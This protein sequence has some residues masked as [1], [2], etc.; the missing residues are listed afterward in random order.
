MNTNSQDQQLNYY[1][2]NFM[3]KNHKGYFI[4]IGGADGIENSNT[5]HLEKHLGWDGV[6]IEANPQLFKRLNENRSC[7]KINTACG[8]TSGDALEFICMEQFS[9]FLKFAGK[10]KKWLLD[11]KKKNPK[12]S[13]SI[14]VKTLTEVLCEVDAPP[15]IDFF[16][17]DVEGA[18]LEVLKGINFNQHIFKT[19]LVEHNGEQPK[20][21]NI[22][23]L[24]QEVYGYK[25]APANTFLRDDFY[26]K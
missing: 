6:C 7:K 16:S 20:R 23:K 5:L 2:E 8:Q 26:Y 22:R 19:I 9:G 13:I 12:A 21:C 14:P 25:R 15:V 1:I 10:Y 24:L 17:L 11:H 3:P 18:E 4:E